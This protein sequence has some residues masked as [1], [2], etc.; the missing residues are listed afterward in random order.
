[1]KVLLINISLRPNS[2]KIL[3]PIGLGYIAT[4]IKRSGHE[5]VLVD[6]DA[7]RPTEEEIGRK[8]ENLDYDVALMGCVA[9]GYKFVKRYAA[10]IKKRK[11]VMVVVGNSVATSIP[12]ILLNKTDVDVAVMG[13]GD[14]TVVEL[15]K[16]IEKND[17]SGVKGICYKKGSVIIENPAREPIEDLDSLLAIDWDIFNVPKYMEKT[18]LFVDEPYPIDFDSLRMMPINSAR[19]CVHRCTFC[20]HVFNNVRYRSRSFAS[21]C[22]EIKSLKEKYGVNYITFSDELTFR[23]KK[24]CVEFVDGML[25]ANLGVWWRASSRADLFGK[26]DLDIVTKLKESGCASLGGA[27]ESANKEILREMNKK[28]TVDQFKEHMLILQ[29]VGITTHTSIVVGY[30]QETPSTLQETF[31]CCYEAN[32]YPSVGYFLPQPG[33]PMYDYAIKMGKIKDEEEY[34]LIANDR[35]DLTVNLTSMSDE[36]FQSVV[37]NGL[38]NL[39]VRL[40]RNMKDEEL[41]KTGHYRNPVKLP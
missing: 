29:K 9:T 6:I 34:L 40:K 13:E 24:H 3:M 5:I 31:D 14:I 2:E 27:L 35:Q 22:D 36:E 19:G 18:K 4:A 15:L 38:K 11:N 17:I 28:I 8:F 25:K 41:I 7:D 30:P 23:S 10:M 16:G 37:R 12:Y 33:T 32:L 20:Y 1:M 26:N 21:V 39:A